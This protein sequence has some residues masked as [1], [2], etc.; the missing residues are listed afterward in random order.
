MFKATDNGLDC[1][2]QRPYMKILTCKPFLIM[3]SILTDIEVIFD[4]DQDNEFF[5]FQS[6]TCCCCYSKYK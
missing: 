6:N 2:W 4:D 3:E 5:W 1:C